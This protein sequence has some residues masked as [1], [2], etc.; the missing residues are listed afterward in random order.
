MDWR[1]KPKHKVLLIADDHKLRDIDLNVDMASV[2]DHR[3]GRAWGLVPGAVIPRYHTRKPY[4]VVCGRMDGPFNA[5]KGKW[6]VFDESEVSRIAAQCADKEIAEL[7]R[8]AIQEMAASIMKLSI[9]GL[10]LAVAVMAAVVAI[11]SGTVRIPG[12]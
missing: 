12:L 6:E 5:R 4:L 10:T 9:A 2:T 3:S 8:R 7:P 11:S 1:R